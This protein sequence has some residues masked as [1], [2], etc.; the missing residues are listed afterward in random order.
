R[1]HY[2][3]AMVQVLNGMV[4][5]LIGLYEPHWCS[6]VKRMR[7]TIM[8]ISVLGIDIGKNNFHLFDSSCVEQKKVRKKMK[9]HKMAFI[10]L[11]IFPYMRWESLSPV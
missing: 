10:S 8:G 1:H 2:A 6:P 4:R 3:K 9:R 5:P 11:G 7:Q